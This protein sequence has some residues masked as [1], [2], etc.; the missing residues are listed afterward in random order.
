MALNNSEVARLK[1]LI[2]QMRNFFSFN[3]T[4]GNITGVSITKADIDK[5]VAP[6]NYIV[7]QGVH[8]IVVSA[9]PPVSPQVGDLWI[10]IS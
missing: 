3:N 2:Y 10:D 4:T 8:K 5:A 9:T 6:D 7:G 1:T